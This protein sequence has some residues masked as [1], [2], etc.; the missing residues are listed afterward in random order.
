MP[1]HQEYSQTPSPYY[2]AM[3]KASSL[4]SHE[5]S[6]HTAHGSLL[7]SLSNF[8]S[9]KLL[10]DPA[11]NIFYENALICRHLLNQLTPHE[12]DKSLLHKRRLLK[13]IVF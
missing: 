4:T 9:V 8:H 3:V 12:I 10:P 1:K 5:R 11:S 13:T 7:I 2:P 6:L